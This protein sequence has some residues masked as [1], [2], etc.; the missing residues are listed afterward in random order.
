MKNIISEHRLSHNL[1]TWLIYSIITY[2]I[3]I[4]FQSWILNISISLLIGFLFGLLN[5][6]ILQLHK[7]NEKK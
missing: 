3:L 1:L 4:P 5:D 6:I 2:I 7:L